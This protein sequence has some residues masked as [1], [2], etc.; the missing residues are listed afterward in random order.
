MNSSFSI[1]SSSTVEFINMSRAKNKYFT[2]VRSLKELS[3]YDLLIY[4]KL[5]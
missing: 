1:H 3:A 2:F 5:K 4:I